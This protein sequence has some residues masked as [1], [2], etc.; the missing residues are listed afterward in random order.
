VASEG[1][2]VSESRWFRRRESHTREYAG[3]DDF[4]L[5]FRSE[6]AVLCRLALLLTADAE[7]V[8]HC[9]VRALSECMSYTSVS[10][11]WV[12]IWARRAVIRNAIRFIFDQG[13]FLVMVRG[14]KGAELTL[15]TQELH[16]TLRDSVAIT[17]LPDLERFAYVICVLENYSVHDCAL[18]LGKPT[19]EVHE[20]KLRASD[21]IARFD[22]IARQSTKIS[23]GSILE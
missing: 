10:K 5:F 4:L 13:L 7:L 8:E 14:F 16:E 1:G 11:N 19:R 3:T 17:D 12:P 18:L 23:H 9:L 21:Q 20:A 6:K 15:S 2:K 22:T